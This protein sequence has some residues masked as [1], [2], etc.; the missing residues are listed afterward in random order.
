[1]R[2]SKR[3]SY[4]DLAVLSIKE[5]IKPERYYR[6]NRQGDREDYIQGHAKETGHEIGTDIFT[7]K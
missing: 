7:T 3:L 4:P 6:G 1:M 5:Q 2:H